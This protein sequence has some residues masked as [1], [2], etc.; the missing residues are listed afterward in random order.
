MLSV[1]VAPGAAAQLGLGLVDIC[2]FPDSPLLTGLVVR[3]DGYKSPDDTGRL[4]QGWS[5]TRPLIHL[6][7]GSEELP[8]QHSLQASIIHALPQPSA[9]GEPGSKTMAHESCSF[10]QD[11]PRC[12]A[13]PPTTPIHRGIYK[14]RLGLGAGSPDSLSHSVLSLELHMSRDATRL[15]SWKL[16]CTFQVHKAESTLKRLLEKLLLAHTR[17]PWVYSESLTCRCVL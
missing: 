17:Q 13:G 5:P 10:L 4:L 9:T 15:F 12:S 1:V 6:R 7:E 2:P 11:P 8:N 14:I 3:R 16:S